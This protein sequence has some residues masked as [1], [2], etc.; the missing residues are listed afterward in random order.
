M[1]LQVPTPVV[2]ETEDY[3]KEK[4][5]NEVSQDMWSLMKPEPRGDAFASLLA[6]DG[7]KDYKFDAKFAAPWDLVAPKP[8]VPLARSR[9]S[10]SNDSLQLCT[11]GL[12]CESC[13]CLSEIADK[14]LPQDEEIEVPF[15]EEE[16]EEEEEEE[17]EELEEKNHP[18]RSFP[19]PLHSLCA[20]SAAHLRSFKKD[21]RFVLQSVKA[22]LL[23]FL[24]SHREGGRL[25]MHLVSTTEDDDL[26]LPLVPKPQNGVL[27]EE[28]IE[29]GFGE[30]Q[31]PQ[32]F[33]NP[34]SS[35]IPAVHQSKPLPE[36]E[37]S[38]GNHC[39]S[40]MECNKS[41]A[42][43]FK[44]TC[45]RPPEKCKAVDNESSNGKREI[46][47]G[48]SSPK[49]SASCQNIY[50]GWRTEIAEQNSAVFCQN[51]QKAQVCEV[52]GDRSG[53]GKVS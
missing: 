9:S 22:P 26:A 8:Y 28:D 12:G 48:K 16:N 34:V 30:D 24:H 11:E 37:D 27:P 21:G 33:S 46:Q 41:T 18:A 5:E 14:N 45:N 29:G 44:V 13:D 2:M 6:G 15:E 47:E 43:E 23:N 36:P 19:P 40:S 32:I 31:A 38:S 3:L 35:D 49:H 50:S 52:P 17:V 42:L 1:R 53:I 7:G 51:W 4:E 10:L 25:Q 20:S 39:D